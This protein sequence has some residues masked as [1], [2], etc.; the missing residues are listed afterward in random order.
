MKSPVKLILSTAIGAVLIVTQ[1]PVRAATPTL[2]HPGADSDVV[3]VLPAANRDPKLRV[4]ARSGQLNASEMLSAANRHLALARSTGDPRELGR[5]HAQLAHPRLEQHPGALLMRASIS[6][7]RHDFSDARK[8]LVELVAR[9]PDFA[10]AWMMLANT[11][12]IL[13]RTKKALDACKRA[14]NIRPSA[15]H[16]VC[17]A[18]LAALQG[19][20]Q[21]AQG[22]LD[23]AALASKNR[24]S[25]WRSIVQAEMAVRRADHFVAQRHFRRAVIQPDVY[26]LDS[27][28]QWL[29][30]RNRPGTAIRLINTHFAQDDVRPDVL[31]LRLLQAHYQLGDLERVN[32]L[33]AQLEIRFDSATASG[34]VTAHLRERT[35]LALIQ[36]DTEAALTL[37][38]QNWDVQRE[39]ADAILLARA[40]IQASDGK[41]LA[42]LRRFVAKTGFSDVR[43]DRLLSQVAS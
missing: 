18:D 16:A 22:W 4:A 24:S 28:T 20:H 41:V 25:T 9:H 30:D 32:Q 12:R 1:A 26:V 14:W 21:Q 34:Q 19:R 33:A 8:R 17:L 13:G 10:P 37:A 2:I 39:S 11:D 15:N 38:S 5:A 6:Q 31:M 27:Y 3:A 35:E 42:S 40:A 36:G 23:K 43:L 29:I 7:S